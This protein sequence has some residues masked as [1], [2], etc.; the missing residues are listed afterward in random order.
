MNLCR[1][2]QERW[3]HWRYGAGF[4]GRPE[5]FGPLH[6]VSLMLE[7]HQAFDHAGVDEL[8]VSARNLAD[9]LSP[10]TRTLPDFDEQACW[11]AILDKAGRVATGEFERPFAVITGTV[12]V[13]VTEQGTLI[14]RRIMQEQ[15]QASVEEICPKN[16]GLRELLEDIPRRAA[17]AARLREL[18]ARLTRELSDEERAAVRHVTPDELG[19]CTSDEPLE[20][21]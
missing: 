10:V 15:R 12:E 16:P 19:L 17:D 8:E 5:S 4:L 20:G 18:E 1:W 11:Q 2:L 14:F 13:F 21:P 9:Y 6:H 7:L 3:L